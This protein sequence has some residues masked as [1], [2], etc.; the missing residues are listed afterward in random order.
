[1]RFESGLEAN[2]VVF[3]RRTNRCAPIWSEA[4][5]AVILMSW[6]LAVNAVP[7]SRHFSTDATSRNSVLELAENSGNSSLPVPSP[8]QG[9]LSNL[10]QQQEHVP[11]KRMSTSELFHNARSRHASPIRISE[12]FEWA[13]VFILIAPGT[14]P[15]MSCVILACATFW[16]RR[17][18]AFWGT[19]IQSNALRVS[20]PQEEDVSPNDTGWDVAKPHHRG[21]SGLLGG[22]AFT[23]SDDL[24]TSQSGSSTSQALIQERSNHLE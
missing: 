6:L 7:A 3:R 18:A 19:T 5:F 11:A 20:V 8:P 15:V 14:F 9:G 23:S 24:I 21:H 17:S 2:A 13:F 12:L 22:S 1:M 4:T 16:R 10:T